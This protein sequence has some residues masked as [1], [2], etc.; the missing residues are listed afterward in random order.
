MKKLILIVLFPFLIYSQTLQKS[1]RDYQRIVLDVL[2]DSVEIVTPEKFGAKGDGVT[3]DATAIYN[4]LYYNKGKTI[5]FSGQYKI[6]SRVHIDLQGESISLVFDPDA[7]ITSTSQSSYGNTYYPDALFRI[8]NGKR[9]IISGL[10]IEAKKT[11]VLPGLNY[12]LNY[13]NTQDDTANFLCAFKIDSTEE[14]ILSNVKAKN[15]IFAGIMISDVDNLYAENCVADSNY[16]AGM[17]VRRTKHSVINGGEFSYNGISSTWYGVGYYNYGYGLEFGNAVSSSYGRFNEEITVTGV[18]A[19]YNVRKGIGTH[20][21]Y[22]FTV[23]GNHVKGFG[24]TGIDAGNNGYEQ[25]VKDVIIDGN[26]IEQDSVWYVT[27]CFQTYSPIAI[28]VGTYAGQNSQVNYSAGSILITNNIIKNIYSPNMNFAIQSFQSYA[29]NINISNNSISNARFKQAIISVTSGSEQG[30]QP[31]N[32]LVSGNTIKNISV[33]GASDN[34]ESGIF[35]TAGKQISITNNVIDAIIVTDTTNAGI[36]VFQYGTGSD[37]N[38][39]NVKNNFIGGT[40]R[41]GI[42]L[43]GTGSATVS[44]NLLDGTFTDFYIY[45]T[46]ETE[47]TLLN[48]YVRGLYTITG[49]G[50]PQSNLLPNIL[51]NGIGN[52]TYVAQTSGSANVALNT[53]SLDMLRYKDI[54][55]TFNIRVHV[56]SSQNIVNGY[57]DYYAYAGNDNNVVG[58]GLDTLEAVQYVNTSAYAF[59]TY[60]PTVQWVVS[61][62]IATLKFT[63]PTAYMGYKIDINF[64]SRLAVIYQKP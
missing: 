55:A 53:I 25:W 9:V 16:Y 4:T 54:S 40:L 11:G 33:L 6:N 64:D 52:A 13:I 45:V 20:Q 59:A 2:R 12:N 46:P 61:G 57:I 18:K 30:G 44:D 38:S 3:D 17:L 31:T 58:Y 32:V 47:Q 1:W 7:K 24:I 50:A 60:C 15:A 51:G 48:N 41:N 8:T 42:Y 5:L 10:Q 36:K 27:H 39:V 21:A 26:T 56:A 37:I 14:A 35:V 28:Q 62:S 23:Q 22:N 49:T 29:D 43:Y 63:F 19:F 34:N